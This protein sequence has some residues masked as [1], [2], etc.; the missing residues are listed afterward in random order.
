MKLYNTM[1]RV[2][3]LFE[4][5]HDDGVRLYACGPTVYSE[6]HLGNLRTY[7]FVDILVRIMI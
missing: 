7:L 2:K 4:P 6:A 3:E 1:G 5:Q